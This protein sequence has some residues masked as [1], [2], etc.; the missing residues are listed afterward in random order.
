[1]SAETRYSSTL[2]S[3]VSGVTVAP[4]RI[5][6]TQDRTNS[7]YYSGSLVV[8]DVHAQLALPGAIVEGV[9]QI[10][11]K[12]A[13]PIYVQTSNSGST[14]RFSTLVANGIPLILPATSGVSYYVV[15]G[16]SLTSD[17]DFTILSD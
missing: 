6:V 1:M 7:E 11:N 8:T 14:G 16:T 2:T 3:T 9:F 12:G 13:N 15:C 17:A 4:P 10:S 5:S